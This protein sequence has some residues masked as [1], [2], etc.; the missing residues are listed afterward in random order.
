M[1][2]RK[3]KKISG[4]RRRQ[5]MHGLGAVDFTN[6]LG[7]VAGAVAG[8]MINK[9]IPTDSKIDPRLVSASKLGLGIALPMFSKSGSTKNILAG[10]GAGMVAVG[11]VELIKA[12]APT[13]ISGLG[14][15]DFIS[16]S[17]DGIGESVL[18]EDVLSGDIDVING[19]ISVVNGEDED[20]E[21]Y[22]Y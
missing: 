16:V 15:D 12:V 1:A 11:S 21:D 19:D 13:M 14:E 22:M 8:S 9:I 18:A 17:L 5:R 4:V 7:V 20:D 10:V 3:R 2:K 6:V